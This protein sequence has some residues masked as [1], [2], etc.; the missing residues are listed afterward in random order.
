MPVSLRRQQSR[1]S[2]ALLVLILLTWE[3]AVRFGM[4]SE[5]ILPTFSSV[6]AGLPTVVTSPTSNFT[7]HLWVTTQEVFVGFGVAV[8]AGLVLGAL[9]ATWEAGRRVMFP[10]LVMVEVVPKVALVPLLIV[11]LGY[12]VASKAAV[13]ALLAFFP[14]FLNSLQ[15]LSSGDPQAVRLMRSLR[16]GK[17]QTLRYYLGPQALPLIFSGLKLALTLAFIG[18][19]VGEL[20]TLQSGLGYLIN[21]LKQQLRMDLAYATTII[22]AALGAGLFFSMEVLERRLLHWAPNSRLDHAP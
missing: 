3:F 21:S 8:V 1:D 17:F 4:V 14:M 9:L 5:R 19:I 20:L 2:L 10:V 18:A 13:A 16:A 11:A 12:G 7:H 22:V 6:V 15:G